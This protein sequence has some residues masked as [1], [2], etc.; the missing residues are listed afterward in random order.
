LSRASSPVSEPTPRL[1]PAPPNLFVGTSGWA[2]PTW[3]PGFYPANVPARAFLHEYASRLTSVEV[4]YTFRSLP[5]AE[6]LESW[7]AATPPG[8]L[9]SF[10]A[11]QQITHFQRLQ[12]S[13]AAAA[14]FVDALEPARRAGKLGI[15]LFQLPA[16]FKLSLDR[17]KDFL[18]SPTFRGKRASRIAFEFRHPSWFD[19]ETYTLLS[20]SHAALCVAESD[21]LQTPDIATT[22]FRCYRLRRDGGYSPAAIRKLAASFTTLAQ[23]TPVFAYFKHEDEPTGALNAEALLH[24]AS[25]PRKSSSIASTPPKGHAL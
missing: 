2:Y 23:N 17:L 22:D 5:T 19:E 24:A 15:L 25:K 6:R 4:N 20:K 12:N 10:K 11:P 14:E 9:F 8:F 1:A 16:N 13:H 7:L 3:K 21:D 18:A